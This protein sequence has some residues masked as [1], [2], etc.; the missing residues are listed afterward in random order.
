MKNDLT[1]GVCLVICASR[2]GGGQSARVTESGPNSKR[3]L[4]PSAEGSALHVPLTRL[5][6]K[7]MYTVPSPFS[8]IA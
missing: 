4:E 7:R 2:L 5:H 3:P 8:R 6:L 1:Y